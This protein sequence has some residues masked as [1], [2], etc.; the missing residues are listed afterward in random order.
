MAPPLRPAVIALAALATISV[1]VEPR[2]AGRGSVEIP[3]DW[4]AGE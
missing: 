3:A 4:V 2:V 1:V